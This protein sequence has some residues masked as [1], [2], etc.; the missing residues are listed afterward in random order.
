MTSNE[1][2]LYA[3]TGAPVTQLAPAWR[4]KCLALYESKPTPEQIRDLLGEISRLTV[5]D[6]SSFVTRLCDPGYT[7]TDDYMHVNKTSEKLRESTD[8]PSHAGSA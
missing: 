8:R 2:I 3:L 1:A 4:E 6:A 5:A 7:A